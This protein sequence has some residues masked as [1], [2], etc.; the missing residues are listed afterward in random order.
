[1]KYMKEKGKG[2]GGKEQMKWQGMGRRGVT[3]GKWANT[4]GEKPG[5]EKGQGKE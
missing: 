2:M 3:E 1:M 5:Q 4:E